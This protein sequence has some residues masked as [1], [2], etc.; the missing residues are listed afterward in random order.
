MEATAS[1]IMEDKEATASQNPDQ[2]DDK[3]A[4]ATVSSAAATGPV[5]L[6]WFDEEKG[7]WFKK[8]KK[9]YV[10]IYKPRAKAGNPQEPAAGYVSKL[11]SLDEDDDFVQEGWSH[12]PIPEEIAKA[13]ETTIKRSRE[14]LA[15][16]PAKKGKVDNEPGRAG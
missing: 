7:I 6:S 11:V 13:N 15:I 14:A 12:I 10:S 3:E 2:V 5:V 8:W 1:L 9:S 16:P 4:T